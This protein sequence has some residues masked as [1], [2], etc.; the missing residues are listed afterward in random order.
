MITSRVSSRSTILMQRLTRSTTGLLNRCS[1]KLYTTRR[2][3]LISNKSVST[4]IRRISNRRMIRFTIN[5][6][7]SMFITFFLQW[8]L[9]ISIFTNRHYHT[10]KTFHLLIPVL[11]RRTKRLIHLLLPTT[12]RRPNSKSPRLPMFLRLI[13]SVT[14]TLLNN[15]LPSLMFRLFQL[16]H[17]RPL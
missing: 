11:I 17:I 12:R 2:R 3:S 5:R 13:S 14:R 4:L 9:T 7:P 15:R 16:L 8:Q 6:P 1:T 10:V